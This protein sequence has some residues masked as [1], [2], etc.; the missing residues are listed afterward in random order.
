MEFYSRLNQI[1]TGS[2]SKIYC[3]T[4]SSAHKIP[5]FSSFPDGGAN[6]GL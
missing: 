6:T 3:N 5:S 1:N 4:S 2:L